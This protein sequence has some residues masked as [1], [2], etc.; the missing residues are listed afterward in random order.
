MWNQRLDELKAF[1]SPNGHCNVPYVYPPNRK[2]GHWVRNQRTQYSRRRAGKKHR[3][4]DERMRKLE[5]L[6]FSWAA[7][8]DREYDFSE[9]LSVDDD[10]E[11]PAAPA[12][13]R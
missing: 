8:G 6:G 13:K 3:L 5:E 12:L 9:E 4:T 2:L 10:V 7:I 11:K 1:R